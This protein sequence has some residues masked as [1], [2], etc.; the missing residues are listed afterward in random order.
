MCVAPGG[1]GIGHPA[2]YPGGP[3]ARAA[4][5]GR[6]AGVDDESRVGGSSRVIRYRLFCDETLLGMDMDGMA[7]VTDF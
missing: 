1:R 5:S 4:V 3:D 7:S 2:E 6:R